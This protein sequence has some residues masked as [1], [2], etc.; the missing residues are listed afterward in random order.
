MSSRA[1]LT[2][3]TGVRSARRFRAAAVFGLVL[4][5]SLMSGCGAPFNISPKAAVPS[6]TNMPEAHTGGL[7]FQ[8]QPVTDQDFLYDAFN[9]NPIMAG[10][11]PVWVRI[12]NSGGSPAGLEKAEF[13]LTG[14]DSTYKPFE[15]SK[16]F[17]RLLK[18]YQIKASS[19]FG[20]RKSKDDFESTALDLTK[21][22]LAGS[23]RE[24]YVFF[25]VPA[26]PGIRDDRLKL[27]VKKVSADHSETVEISF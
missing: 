19:T 14:A 24:G 4:G 10:I 9:S 21:P 17:K 25:S 23:S 22:I 6:L 8:A 16:A 5:V 26:E 11:F 12:T 27:L 2:E 13:L 18:Y 3:P 20:F 15:P 7:V 1:E